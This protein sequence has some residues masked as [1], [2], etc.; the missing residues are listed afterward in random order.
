MNSKI[1]RGIIILMI[2]V[3]LL[4]ISLDMTPDFHHEGGQAVEN[5][6]NIT[7][8]LGLVLLTVG[9][10][11]SAKGFSSKNVEISRQQPVGLKPC[12]F[13]AELIKEEAKV[14]RYCQRDVL[15]EIL[16]RY[17]GDYKLASNSFFIVTKEGETLMA[18]LGDEAQERLL[19]RGLTSFA[20]EKSCRYCTFVEK[21]GKVSHIRIR[22]GGKEWVA[23]K[24]A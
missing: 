5:L 11:I 8:L 15:S 2:G 9:G 24:V 4:I 18:Q 16:D 6:Q 19:P 1:T 7:M 17:V 21:D 14:C 20:T 3:V 22:E 23:E 13:C 10:I 12:P